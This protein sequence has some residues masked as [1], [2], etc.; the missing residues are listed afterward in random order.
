MKNP[1]EAIFG[2]IILIFEIT[3]S[4]AITQDGKDL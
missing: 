1:N 3:L 2:P 4:E